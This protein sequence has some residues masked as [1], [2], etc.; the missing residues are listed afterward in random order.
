MSGVSRQDGVTLLPA[1]NVTGVHATTPV[2][3]SRVT[4][5]ER[6]YVCYMVRRWLILTAAHTVIRTAGIICDEGGQ[7][8]NG[9]RHVT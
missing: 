3:A 6:G 5:N 2:N 8:I 7:L 4:G 1:S 9:G